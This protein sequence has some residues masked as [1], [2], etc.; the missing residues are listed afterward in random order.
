MHACA[1]GSH[2][3][4][5]RAAA[6]AHPQLAGKRPELV[7]RVAVG[8]RLRARQQ[9]VARKDVG[10]VL[11]AG[12]G[13]WGGGWCGAR[14]GEGVGAARACLQAAA[15]CAAREAAASRPS[16]GSRRA[17]AAHCVLVG[18]CAFLAPTP[19]QGAAARR[20]RAP[21]ARAK[22]LLVLTN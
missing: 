13:L 11:G 9:P 5:A 12:R 4:S 3:T 18:P 6:A 16:A 15:R 2:P 21:A 14:R 20:G 7:A 22:Q 19:Q 8:R 10:K 1:P 17:P